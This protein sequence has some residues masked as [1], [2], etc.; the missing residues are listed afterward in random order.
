[1]FKSYKNKINKIKDNVV[2]VTFNEDRLNPEEIL[3]ESQLED[4][5]FIRSIMS[6]IDQLSNADWNALIRCILNIDNKINFLFE[7]RNSYY[8]D[9][10]IELRKVK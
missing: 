3:S 8:N 6:D 2:F 7:E 5:N 9:N 1:M 4:F 10:V